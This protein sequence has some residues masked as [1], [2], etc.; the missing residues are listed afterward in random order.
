MRNSRGRTLIEL[1]I[2]LSTT[3][4]LI[5]AIGFHF[6]GWLNNCRAES[7]VKEMYV[8]LM[9][10]RVRAMQQNR[11]HFVVINA[12]NYKVF[13]D[14]NDNSQY[15]A[16]TDKSTMFAA[17]KE[18]AKTWCLWTGTVIIDDRGLA[19]TD[20]GPNGTIRFDAGAGDPDYDCIVVSP[21]RIN[22]GKW[23]GKSCIAR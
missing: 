20:P 9:E 19:R 6:Q 15:D 12:D 18:P 11:A 10:A 2:V 17:P 8:D 13:E 22:M 3:V 14:T 16:G 5:S 23:D 1:V 7:E 4:I 21:T